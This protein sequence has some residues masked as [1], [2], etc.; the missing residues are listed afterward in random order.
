MRIKNLP[1]LGLAALFLY[2]PLFAEGYRKPSQP[3]LDVLH[4]PAVPNF[5]LNQSRDAV[6]L[7]ALVEYPPISDLAEPYLR[8]AGVRLVTQNRRNRDSWYWNSYKLVAVPSG[9]ETVLPLPS[10]ARASA[11]SWSPDGEA[12]AFFNYGK[13]SVELWTGRKDGTAPRRVSGVNVNLMLG[14]GMQWMPDGETLLLKTVPHKQGPAPS[15]VASAEPVMQETDGGRGPSSTYEVRDVLQTPQDEKLFDYYAESDL[16]LVNTR[17]G[18]VS[19]VAGPALFDGVS[20]SPDGKHLLVTI[21]HRPYSHLTTYGRFPHLVKILALPSGKAEYKIADLPLEDDVPISGVPEGPRS[22]NW[23]A[24]E[25]ATLLWAEALDGGDWDRPA[26]MRDRLMLVKA[27]FTAAPREIMRL[28]TRFSGIQWSERGFALVSETDP[29]K[30]RYHVTQTDF[31][32]PDFAPRVIWDRSSDER[33]EN[34]GRPVTRPRSDGTSV[35]E[36]DGDYIYLSGTGASPDGERPFLDRFNMKDFKTERLFRCDRNS[37]ETFVTFT[38]LKGGKFL[39]CR[40]SPND[41]PNLYLRSLGAAVPAPEGEAVRESS[42]VKITNVAD[43][44]PQLRSI[45]RQLVTY[46]RADGVDLSFT[47]YLP[48][49]Y[50]EGQKL[51]AVLWAYPLDYPDPKMAGQVVGSTKR[52]ITIGWPLQEFFLLNG[53][54]LIDS[55]LMPVIG[56]LNKIYDTYT[57]Q[58]VAGAKA[59]V[60]K[61]ATLGM[62]DTDRIGVTGHS[63]GGLMTANLL[64]NTD[65]FRAGIARSGA[66]NRSL[67]AFGFQSERRT[68]W[69][70]PDVY[71]KV[72]SYFHA[73]KL[74]LPIMIIHGMEDANP[75]TTPYQSQLLYEA[76]RG[77]GGTAKLIML[78][79]ESHHY[80][81]MESTEHVLAEMMDW[82]DKYVKN[83]PPRVKTQAG[84]TAP[85]V[86]PAAEK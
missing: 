74:K 71:Y 1:L 16:T 63:H 43:P 22:F 11:P 13:K 21:V 17:T 82:F 30:R 9:K 2:S 68:L 15:S 57:D 6:I 69:Q 4:A 23:R 39:T 20:R 25:P 12:Y 78:P 70:A 37:Y 49:D 36:E 48:P 62:I 42:A 58:L 80:I 8:L 81:S 19:R 53:Y 55:P 38:D 40:E 52:F 32:R 44:T 85:A 75:G 10:D 76:L 33:Y 73:D 18:H 60:E 3:I 67:T 27:P 50:K 64:L 86:V 61:A 28:Q 7:A 14:S 47:L 51:P 45:K 24:A 54:A 5:F 41:P 26:E 31:D 56:D 83:A 46:K 77:N 79:Y 59:A 29:I 72:S 66:Y 65:L 35:I 84:E 34:P